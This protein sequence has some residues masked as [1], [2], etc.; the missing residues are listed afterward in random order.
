MYP[1]YYRIQLL[2]RAIAC[3]GKCEY[4]DALA[5]FYCSIFGAILYRRLLLIECLLIKKLTS[6]RYDFI[7][8]CLHLY[9]DRPVFHKGFDSR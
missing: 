6:D 5:F 7:L 9:S 8:I 3:Q 1:P 4:T 2:N